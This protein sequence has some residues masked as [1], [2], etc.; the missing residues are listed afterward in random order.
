MEEHFFTVPGRL[1]QP[2]NPNI[3]TNEM[4]TPFFLFDSIFLVALVA[5]LSGFLTL[6]DVEGIPKLAPTNQFP[7][8][9]V[10]G[11]SIY[12]TLKV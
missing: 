9:E 1:V 11:S 8:R 4:R 12:S 5:S 7:Y 2:V 3:S 6:S 10:A